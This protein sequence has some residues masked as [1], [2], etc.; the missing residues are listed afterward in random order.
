MN[1][2]NSLMKLVL[3]VLLLLVYFKSDAQRNDG[4]ELLD[5]SLFVGGLSPAVLTKGNIEINAFGSLFS[6]WIGL[7]QSATVE[8][9]VLDR[10][11]VTDFNTNIEGY[12]GINRYGR[13][14][15]GVRLRY[16]RQRVASAARDSPFDVFSSDS[17]EDNNSGVDKTYKGLRQLGLR[18]RAVP[19]ENLKNLTINAGYS[20][21]KIGSGSD[22][23][24]FI[25]ADRNSVDV[26]LTYY[27]ELNS[28]SFYYFVFNGM[29][30][31]AGSLPQNAE[32]LHNVSGSF[33]LAHRIGSL[34]IYPGLTYS[35]EF[36]PPSA[37]SF[38]DKALIKRGEQLLGS[39][40]LQINPTDKA[41][42][43]INATI[44][45]IL[46]S[47]NLRQRLI[48]ESYSFVSIGT[49]ILI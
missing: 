26:N 45:F 5:E 44:P 38:S 21:G 18:V 9:P 28:N 29:S 47:T 19:F 22:D 36:K 23:E 34:V 39:V 10:L 42:F 15:I 24:S 43:N 13:F 14:D 4:L 32:A 25:L 11:R 12:Y 20:F 41:S 48:R 7:H 8:S 40:G 30:S 33:F 1:N 3:A 37:A 16:G 17:A 31:S 46:S 27:L 2:Q 49:R 35:M 6:S